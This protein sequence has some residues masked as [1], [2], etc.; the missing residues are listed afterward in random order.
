MKRTDFS[1]TSISG[2]DYAQALTLV[3]AVKGQPL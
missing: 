2:S 3:E 1:Y